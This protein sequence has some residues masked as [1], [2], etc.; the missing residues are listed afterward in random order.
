MVIEHHP[1]QLEGLDVVLVEQQGLLKALSGCLKIAQFPREFNNA[2]EHHTGTSANTQEV[3]LRIKVWS[4]TRCFDV[5]GPLLMLPLYSSVAS[6]TS[7]LIYF[8]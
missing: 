7:H 8:F 4:A 5:G 6:D 2:C 3:M 1:T